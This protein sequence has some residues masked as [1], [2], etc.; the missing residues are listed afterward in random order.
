MAD[1]TL[2]PDEPEDTTP[3]APVAVEAPSEPVK[4]KGGRPR[5]PVD[6]NAPPKRPPG[7][8]R[9]TPALSAPEDSNQEA[10]DALDALS[11][12]S[13]VAM[14]T[15]DAQ[16]VMGAE[17]A[18]LVQLLEEGD[19]DGANDLL[20]K[21]LIQS[22]INLIAQVEKGV[23]DTN[24]RYGVH[25]FNGLVMSIRELIND[26]QAQKDRGAIGQILV[27]SVLRPA[28]RISVWRSCRNSSNR[29]RSARIFCASTTITKSR[30]F[31]RQAVTR[32]H[33]TCTKHMKQCVTVLSI[34]S[35]AKD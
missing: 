23:I 4:N 21:R 20:Q 10:D 16:N 17:A 11:K 6:P 33:S 24:G 9:K 5:K 26:M 18:R 13:V 1:F 29:V 7:R 34:T 27:E 3:T 31:R 25:S 19:D 8:P 32:L 2:L 14:T 35:N 30:K 15:D 28:Y 22:S 12:R